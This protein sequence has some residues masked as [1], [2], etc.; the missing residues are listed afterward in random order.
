MPERILRYFQGPLALSALDAGFDFATQEMGW[1]PRYRASLYQRAAEAFAPEPSFDAFSQ[2]YRAKV[3]YWK[4]YRG[5]KLAKAEEIFEMLTTGCAAASRH[6]VHDTPDETNA[7]I[8]AAICAM[9]KVKILRGYP[10]MAASKFLHFYNPVLFPIYDGA[11]IRNLVLRGAFRQEWEQI[12]AEYDSQ[13]WEGSEAFLIAYTTWAAKV[14]QTADPA[15]MP[16][17]AEKFCGYCDGEVAA[18]ENI[19]Q[20]HAAAFEYLLM[21]AARIETSGANGAG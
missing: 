15:I 9:E 3:S 7:A 21:G 17:F 14:M 8:R 13:F 10:N 4:I 11:V 12:C 5:G 18:L 19:A 6:A 16:A 2:L 20:Y 1:S